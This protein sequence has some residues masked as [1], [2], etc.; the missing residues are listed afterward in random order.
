MCAAGMPAKGSSN[1][2]SKAIFAFSVALAILAAS[3][4]AGIVRQGA[5]N[6][7]QLFHGVPIDE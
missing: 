2:A 3:F 6:I 5:Q 4:S 1:M 7:D